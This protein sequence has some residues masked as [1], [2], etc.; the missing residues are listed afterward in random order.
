MNKNVFAVIQARMGSSRLPGKTLIPIYQGKPV[1]QLML[2]RVGRS[3]YID[4]IVIA[5][6]REAQDD[7]L[8]HFCDKHG[9]ACFRGSENDV[10]DRFYHAALHVGTPDVIVR[11]TGD[12]PLH[13]PGVL[14]KTVEFFLEENLDF[15][16]NVDPPT[17]PDG[18]DTEVFTFDALKTAWQ[19]AVNQDER[20]HVTVYIK[21]HLE[22]FRQKGYVNSQDL[23]Y[24]VWTIDDEKDLN[25]I[26]AIYA[27]LYEE[28]PDFRINDIIGF[29]EEHPELQSTREKWAHVIR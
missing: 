4:S 12:C 6:S 22:L 25:F 2:E 16:S 20:E 23:S 5:T 7:A 8:E 29:L 14:D 24:H 19:Q 17:F 11:L 1:L 21:R 9:Y 13:D 28:N 26:R 10:L 27:N 3:N 15:G 18:L